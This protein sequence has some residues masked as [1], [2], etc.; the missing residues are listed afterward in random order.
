[1]RLFSYLYYCFKEQFVL[2]FEFWGFLFVSL[3]TYGF[4]GIF[5]NNFFTINDTLGGATKL[6][7][8][9]LFS[10][11]ILM[12]LVVWAFS[13]SIGQYFK[14]VQRGQIEAFKTQP[15]P[16]IYLL[17][18][19]W[20]GVNIFG[21]FIILLLTFICA[22]YFFYTI[23]VTWRIG[24]YIGLFLFG[25]II[26]VATFVLLESITFLTK[27]NVPVDFI[28]NEISRLCQL[29]LT[30]FGNSVIY[31]LMLLP[32]L[33]SSSLI[34]AYFQSGFQIIHIIYL[35][36]GGVVLLISWV[37]FHRLQRCFEGHGG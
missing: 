3:F 33:L 16:E 13:G 19:R 24:V 32:I 21:V 17:L 4:R 6:E 1:M 34:L 36:S 23:E 2:R 8:L 14:F 15:I 30:L 26:N 7:I 18:F 9:I 22:L 29:P 28:Y 20:F 27:R 11:S 12:G 10:I 37:I 35:I 5:F 31:M 25:V